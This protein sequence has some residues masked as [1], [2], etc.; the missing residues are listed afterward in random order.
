MHAAA[1][2]EPFQ[3]E[4]PIPVGVQGAGCPEAPARPFFASVATAAGQSTCNLE[5]RVCS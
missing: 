2:A 3:I 1:A 5:L 4:A